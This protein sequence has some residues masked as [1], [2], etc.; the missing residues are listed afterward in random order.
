MEQK[1]K[2]TQK[3]IFKQLQELAGPLGDFVK[4]FSE[5]LGKDIEERKKRNIMMGIQHVLIDGMAHYDDFDKFL[6]N[7]DHPVKD[8]VVPFRSEGV[9][10]LLSDGTFDFIRKP[11]IRAQSELIKKLPHGRLSKT[12]D[13]AIQLTL[14]V[15]Q[16]EGVN[17]SQ[18]IEEEALQ[19]KAAIVEW[20]MKR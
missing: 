6:F 2:I 1:K 4:E 15:Y 3:Q 17:I 18:A 9:G 19:A 7:P 5:K 16:D 12:K 8:T 14:K 11:R 13:G 20:Q 10:Q